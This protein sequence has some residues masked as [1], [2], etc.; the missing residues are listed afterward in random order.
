MRSEDEMIAQILD[1][2]NKN[3]RVRAV[4]LTGSRADPLSEKDIL[5]DFDVIY[6]VDQIA[7]VIKD[8]RWIDIFGDRL[9]LQLPDEMT[10][11]KKDDHVF[12]YLM[13]FKDHTRI[14]LTLFPLE[15]LN[16]EFIKENFTTVLLDKDDLFRQPGAA[17]QIDFA[18]TRPTEKEF[19]DC[20]NEFWWVSAYVAKGLYRDEIIYAKH[21]MEIPVR[22]MFFK[23][24]E[25]YVG[26]ETGF[27]ASPGIGGRHMK[28]Y[29]SPELYDQVLA[30]Y[31]DSNKANIWMSLFLMTA[32]FDDLARKIAAS[33]K[34]QYNIE[35]SKNVTE[36][37]LWVRALA[38]QKEKVA[39]SDLAQS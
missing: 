9:I 31:P 17:K 22:N 5:Q 25:W 16:T 34:F 11:G 39:S 14:D 29:L 36:Y 20:C 18:V 7:T 15:K 3:E 30:T 26:T 32:L 12:H 8:Q 27:T 37:L 10:V 24:L 4:L 2:A 28:R 33:L 21:M 19:Q 38:T 35:E 23:I 1:V 13:L 6:I